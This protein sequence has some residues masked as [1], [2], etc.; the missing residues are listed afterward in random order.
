[1]RARPQCISDKTRLRQRRALTDNN[2]RFTAIALN[3][4][5]VIIGFITRPGCVSATRAIGLGQKRARTRYFASPCRISSPVV[6]DSARVVFV[7]VAHA[8]YVRI[9]GSRQTMCVLLGRECALSV[10]SPSFRKGS[11]LRPSR[12]VSY[13]GCRK[14]CDA[15][16]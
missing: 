13:R 12:D 9:P 6:I 14:T 1:M 2:K 10:L 16:I 11:R 5:G 4:R 15:P 8:A 3:I 7:C